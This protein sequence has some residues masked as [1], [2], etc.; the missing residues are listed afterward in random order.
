MAE[1]GRV[2]RDRGISVLIFPEGEGRSLDG[3]KPFKEQ[4]AY[5]AI[6]AGVPVV[7]VALEGTLEDCLS[8]P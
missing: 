4:A 8:T 2:I 7:P 6:N 3:L 1:A 5:I